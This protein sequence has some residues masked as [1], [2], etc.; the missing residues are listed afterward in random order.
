MMDAVLFA[1]GIVEG[2]DL[3]SEGDHQLLISQQ[4]EVRAAEEA[5]AVQSAADVF[6]QRQ[7]VT[8][9]VIIPKKPVE[10]EEP[11]LPDHYYDNGNIPV[12]KPVPSPRC[13][14]NRLDDGPIPRLCKVHSPH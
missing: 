13:P 5:V 11:I 14:S 1:D 9:E 6:T 7:N 4:D 3:T 2:G 10:E 8:V 12:F